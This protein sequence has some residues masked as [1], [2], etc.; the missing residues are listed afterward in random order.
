MSAQ[1]PPDLDQIPIRIRIRSGLYVIEMCQNLTSEKGQTTPEKG[2]TNLKTNARKTIDKHHN[3]TPE[4][5]Q[6]NTRFW[7]QTIKRK[8]IRFWPESYKMFLFQNCS[9]MK[10]IGFE[11]AFDLMKILLCLSDVFAAAPPWCLKLLY[12][13]GLFLYINKHSNWIWKLFNFK[14]NVIN[15]KPLEVINSQK[16]LN[17]DHF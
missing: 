14:K 11:R 17:F 16:Y 7:R 3:L 15:F 4:T 13:N 6:T 2:Q 5:G 9:S 10:I 1:N 8:N 12:E